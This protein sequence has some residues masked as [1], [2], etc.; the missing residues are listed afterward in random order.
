MKDTDKIV[1]D[2]DVCKG[3]ALCVAACPKKIMRLSGRLNK[4]GYNTAECSS[5]DDCISCTLC[6]VM[7]PDTAITVYKKEVK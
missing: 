1:V 6:A 3:C 4:K 7:C 5:Q 2:G